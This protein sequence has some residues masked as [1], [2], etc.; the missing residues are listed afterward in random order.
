MREIHT[1][2]IVQTAR[3]LAMRANTELGDD[4]RAA[5]IAKKALLRPVGSEN[6]DP[7]LARLERQWLDRINRL[8]IGPQGLGGRITSLAVHINTLPTHIGSIP[9]AV[10]LQCHA[11]RHKAMAL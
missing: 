3:E 11:A 5:L 2:Q 10:N 4:V 6:P 8:G 7:Q 9:V 1:N